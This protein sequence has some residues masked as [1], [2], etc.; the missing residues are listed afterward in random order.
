MQNLPAQSAP[1]VPTDPAA[2]TAPATPE[3]DK[4]AP[5]KPAEIPK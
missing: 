1:A 4:S 5:P 2:K 3:A